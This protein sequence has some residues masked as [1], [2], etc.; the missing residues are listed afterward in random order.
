MLDDTKKPE[1][2][3]QILPSVDQLK[4]QGKAKKEGNTKASSS[5]S[6]DSMKAGYDD[7]LDPPPVGQVTYGG[8]EYQVKPLSISRLMKLVRLIANEIHKLTNLEGITEDTSEQEAIMMAI[9]ALDE[10]QIIEIIALVLEVDKKV[11]KDDFQVADA[12]QVINAAFE[13]EDMRKI[14]FQ[15]RQLVKNLKMA[16]VIKKSL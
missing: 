4:E 6:K 7:V 15:I 12:L 8:K 2:G 3:K 9:E 10:E 11:A 14:F 5:D 13:I 16:A 1:E